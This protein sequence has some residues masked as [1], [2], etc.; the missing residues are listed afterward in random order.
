[1]ST[2]ARR[3]QPLDRLALTL[4]MLFTLVMVVLIGLGGR[5]AARV[6]DFSWQNE[7]VGAEDIAF[8]MTFS[9]PMQPK[10]IEQNLDI[11]PPLPGKF[12]WAGRRM[13]YTLDLPI[14]YG[15]T[16]ELSLNQ[17]DDLYDAARFEAYSSSFQSR[18]RAFV[19]VG[20]TG[21]TQGRLV[22]YNLTQQQEVILTPSDWVVLD[23][24]PYPL[25]DRVLFAATDAK[26]Y[27]AGEQNQKLYSATTGLS[28]PSAEPP[29]WQFWRRVAPPQPAEIEQVLDSAAY[30]NLKFDLSP[31]G[32]TIVVQRLSRKNPADFGPWVIAADTEPRRLETDPGGDFM[33]TPDSQSLLL[34]QGEGTAIVALDDTIAE[35]ETGNTLDF[36]PEYGLVLDVADDGTAAA[37]VSFNQNDPEKR[38]TQTLFWVSNQ[39]E[40]KPLL[41]ATGAILDAQFD[42][43][44]ALVYCLISQLLPGETYQVQPYLIAVDVS[45]GEQYSLIAMPPQPMVNM[46]LSPDGLAVLFDETLAVAGEEGT[47]RTGDGRPVSTG[48]LWLLPLFQTLADRIAK[49]PSPV[50]PRELPFQGLNPVWLP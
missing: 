50:Q 27:Q 49:T 17:A 3:L 15:E 35:L 44:N 25:G 10:S 22:L 30:Q 19:Y 31:D 38:F 8:L 42:P 21:E 20:I 28:S 39:G 34:Q 6:R 48:R 18:D 29:R 32:E 33:I 26:S 46:S 40:E 24:Q 11:S 2:K 4:M 14:P 43:T 9:R 41:S 36:L 16:F 7:R 1:M 12:S 47:V 37:M 13:A 23:F 45:T 5:A